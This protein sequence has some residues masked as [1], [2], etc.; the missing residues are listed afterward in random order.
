VDLINIILLWSPRKDS[1]EHTMPRKKSSRSLTDEGRLRLHRRQLF[2]W[3]GG[4]L[5]S[6]RKMNADQKASAYIEYLR[7][8]LDKGLWIKPPREKDELGKDG[9]F[10]INSPI[11]CFTETTLSEIEFHNRTYGK[12]G[13]GFP[14][15]FV[16]THGGRPVNYI[17]AQ[18]PPPDIVICFDLLFISRLHEQWDIN[19]GVDYYCPLV[20]C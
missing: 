16:M 4:N 2:H 6:D 3:I 14:K 18:T 8:S 5:E 7:G 19:C 20:A 17:N 11:C 13:L 15:R 9:E 10:R 1:Q 12:L